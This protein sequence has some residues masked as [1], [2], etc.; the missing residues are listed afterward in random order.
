MCLYRLGSPFA[1]PV[2]RDVSNSEL[3]AAL[4]DSMQDMFK[5]SAFSQ[6]DII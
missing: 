3:R 1:V 5:D 2:S 4:I 6:V